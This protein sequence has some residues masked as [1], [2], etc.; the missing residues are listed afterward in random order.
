M[1]TNTRKYLYSIYPKH[2]INSIINSLYK[3]LSEDYCTVINYTE[4]TV[5]I[6]RKQRL[7]RHSSVGNTFLEGNMT[8]IYIL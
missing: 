3:L 2:T 7:I 6:Q 8:S 1:Q 5:N 4:K